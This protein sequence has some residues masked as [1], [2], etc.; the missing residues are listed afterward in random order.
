ML[1]RLMFVIYFFEVGLLL[2]LVP[3]S[4]FWERNFFVEHLS[5]LGQ[6]AHNYYVRGAV[7]GIGLVSLGAAVTDLLSL[8]GLRRTASEHALDKQWE[9]RGP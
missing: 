2:L 1:S 4:M 7:S 6:I 8:L 5:W 9:P 3:W